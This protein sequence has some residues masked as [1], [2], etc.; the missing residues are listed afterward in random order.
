MSSVGRLCLYCSRPISTED[1]VALCDRCYAAHHEACWDRNGRC[2]TFRCAGLPR[3]MRGD[4]LT[5]ALQAAFLRA[6]ES[7][8]ECPVCMGRVYP[9]VLAGKRPPQCH[10]QPAGTG[11]VFISREQPGGNKGGLGRR[12]IKKLRGRQS[13]YLPGA[14]IRARSCGKCRRL[15]L[16]GVPVDEA[17]MEQCR[18]RE[19]ERFCPHCGTALWPGE[20]PLN[21]HTPGGAR[22]E[23]EDTPDFHRDWIGHNVLDRFFLNR[24]SPPVAALPSHSCA[25]C[26]YTEVAGR[27]VYRFL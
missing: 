2:S 21:P 3:T 22:F 18:E 17:F 11:L 10:D 15:F 23:C 7:P 13:W 26:Q 1:R 6:N 12:L 9:G 27:P 24:W 20:I 19:G 14:H 5:A 25:E 16:W 8:R 4:D